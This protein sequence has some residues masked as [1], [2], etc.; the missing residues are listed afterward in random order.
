[1]WMKISKIMSMGEEI[2][3]H[4]CIFVFIKK[5]IHLCSVKNSNSRNGYRQKIQCTHLPVLCPEVLHILLEMF[6]PCIHV[7]LIVKKKKYTG[8]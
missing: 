5:I 1:M 7:F 2:F 3:V 6:C 4:P 8:P